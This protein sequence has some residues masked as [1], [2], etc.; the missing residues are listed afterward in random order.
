MTSLP[1][2]WSVWATWRGKYSS[3]I[4]GRDRLS[5][6]SKAEPKTSRST[7]MKTWWMSKCSSRI[8]GWGCDGGARP[9]YLHLYKTI[10]TKIFI[11][12]VW[13][14]NVVGAGLRLKR[15]GWGATGR[16]SQLR[17]ISLFASPV[18]RPPPAPPPASLRPTSMPWR[19]TAP[20]SFIFLAAASTLAI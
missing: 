4:D 12:E 19:Q 18:N 15:R 20:S 11:N 14:G 16:A 3:S 13:L 7:S 6:S 17:L 1:K 10:D 2:I 9:D 5:S 8:S